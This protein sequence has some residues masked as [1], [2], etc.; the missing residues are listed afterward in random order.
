M[1]GHNYD[2]GERKNQIVITLKLR[3]DKGI[4]DGLTMWQ[5]AKSLD[6]TPSTHLQRILLEMVKEN[7]LEY[8]VKPHRGET[9]KRVYRLFGEY[10]PKQESIFAF[11][12]SESPEIVI[13]HRGKVVNAS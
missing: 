6:I 1:P 5:L 2:R 4:T 3:I 7:L 13:R 11:N 10:V 12:D 8:E 9:E